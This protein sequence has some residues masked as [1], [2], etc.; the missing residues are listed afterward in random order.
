MISPCR[1]T[2][3]LG[4]LLLIGA[5]SANAQAVNVPKTAR[6]H[7][8]RGTVTHVQRHPNGGHTLRVRTHYRHHKTFHVDAN[9]RVTGGTLHRGEH[10]TVRARRSHADSVSIHHH[11]A[12]HHRRTT[13]A[14]TARVGTTP[15]VGQQQ[16]AGAVRQASVV[17]HHTSTQA[18]RHTVHR[19]KK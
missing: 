15:R 5:A 17:R 13:A 19:R 4:A 10:V 9:T 18:H 3:V 1:V 2:A 12:R 6:S 16:V 11:H 8:Y 7:I 14:T